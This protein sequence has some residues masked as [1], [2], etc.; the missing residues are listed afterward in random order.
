MQL[1]SLAAERDREAFEKSE[2]VEKANTISRERDDLRAKLNSETA[3][4]ERLASEN[5][6]LTAEVSAA[7][8]SLAET[9][10]RA[11]AA[12]AEV[13]SLRKAIE[14]GLGNDPLAL[15]WEAAK[16]KT[17]AGLAFLRSKIPANHPALPWFDKT[18]EVSTKLGCL[19]VRFVV[20]FAKWL[21]AEGLPR[22]KV[23]ADKLLAEVETRLA[24]K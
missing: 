21:K 22:A 2:I 10:R 14:A 19:A 5:S 20:A 24:K 8:R 12:A 18:V 11:D 3:Q 16:Q 1:K 6:R 17:G 4:R 13:A 7:T 9:T 23:L 15:L